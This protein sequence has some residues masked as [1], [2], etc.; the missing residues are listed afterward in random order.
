MKTVQVALFSQRDLDLPT[1]PKEFIKFFQEKFDLVPE[2][3]RD[4][5]RIAL[6]AEM[7]YGDPALELTIWYDRP[8]T[9]KECKEREAKECHRIA[10]IEARERRE[11]ALLQAKYSNP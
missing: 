3:Y 1:K 9:S 8:E 2:Q 7:A 11:L 5:T 6:E 10:S 4:T